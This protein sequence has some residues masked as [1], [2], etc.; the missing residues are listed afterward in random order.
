MKKELKDYLHLYMTY[1]ERILFIE[2]SNYYFVHEHSIHKGDSVLLMP[3]IIAALDLHGKGVEVRLILRP[4]ESMTNKEVNEIASIILRKDVSC[5]RIEWS[6]ER[7]WCCAYWK[8]E[9]SID[10]QYDFVEMGMHISNIGNNF[11]I[12]HVWNYINGNGVGV[13]HEILHNHHEIT[14]YLLSKYFDIFGLIDA[15][16]AIEKK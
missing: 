5:G 10:T 9:E 6:K 8:K 7:D 15:G 2:K 12:D 1:N 13:T 14:K 11:R 16:L 3:H 4:L